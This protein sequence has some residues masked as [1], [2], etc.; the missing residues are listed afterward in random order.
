[1]FTSADYCEALALYL[2]D[3]W[4]SRHPRTQRLRI[5][6]DEKYP[7]IIEETATLL[8]RCLPE[9]RVDV[10]DKSRPGCVNVSVYST[11]LACLFPQH[12]P[13][14]KHARR[15][16][17]EAWQRQLF[18]QAPWAFI[19]GCIHSD[20]CAFV[21]RTGP[22]EYLSYA[23]SNKSADII[24]L[25]CDACDLVDVKYR[26]TINSKGVWHVRINRRESV[27]GMERHV[28]LKR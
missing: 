3:G 2:G 18:E 4:I 25:F 8:R 19:R 16:E 23:F 6:L 11:H 21:N 20:G 13:G 26:A 24:A 17:L 27:A 15:I 10:V 22:Y 28:G 14:R 7:G 9:N 12:G 5:A 1:M